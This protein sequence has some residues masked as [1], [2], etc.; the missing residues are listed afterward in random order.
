M[1]DFVKFLA[2]KKFP[3]FIAIKVIPN[4]PKNEISEKV[5]DKDSKE[6]W[7]IKIAAPPQNGKANKEI[8][9][10]FRKNF[11]LIAKIISGKNSKKKLVKLEQ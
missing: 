2:K 8:E 5:F 11:Q 7:K 4:S 1:D 3:V 6:I 10:F 9:K